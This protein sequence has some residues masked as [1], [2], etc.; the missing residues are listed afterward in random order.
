MC[1]FV[2]H[3]LILTIHSNSTGAITVDTCILFTNFQHNLVY[4]QNHKRIHV[5]CMYHVTQ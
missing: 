3:L 2:C 1:T 4:I 5:H